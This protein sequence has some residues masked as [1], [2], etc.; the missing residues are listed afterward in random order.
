MTFSKGGDYFSD[1]GDDKLSQVLAQ[2]A[3]VVLILNRN[4]VIKDA[5]FKSEELFLS[6]ARG[7]TGR[8]FRDTVTIECE[9]KV[10]DLLAEASKGE[11]K[12]ERE[13]NHS[14]IDGDDAP[15]AYSGLLLNKSGDLILFGQNMSRIASLQRRLMSSQL[16]MEREVSRLRNAENQYRAMFQLSRMPKLVVD[17]ETL[18]VTDANAAA[19]KI[20]GLPPQKLLGKR[21][22]NLFADKSEAAFDRIVASALATTDIRK[23]QLC[24]MGGSEVAVSASHFP[25]DGRSYIILQIQSAESG[26]LGIAGAIES[27]VLALVEDM[28]DAFV[29]TDESR[30]ILHVNRSFCEMINVSNASL[31]EGKSLDTYFERPS[32]DGSVLIANVR[33]HDVVRRFASALRSNFGQVINVDIAARQ[34]NVGSESV[35]GFWLRP[36]SNLVMGAEVEQ[37]N[38][39]R[40]N[41]QIANLVGHMPLKDIVKET[42]EMIEQ[43]CIETALELTQNNRASAAQM[44]GVSRQSLY[45]KLGK[46]RS[47]DDE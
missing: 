1:L 45:S 9:D 20:C 37:E 19:A 34:I 15:V 36:S 18:K 43:L 14:M 25:Q 11:T 39:S 24:L 6:G 40:S 4:G 13:I 8:A 2:A 42:T 46:D 10:D 23:A 47:R 38:I 41:E 35:L 21:A 12:R 26:D 30:N 28:P 22:S 33:K 32:V 31:V 17:T 3:D 29:L 44:L 27:K 5:S 7:W 16:S